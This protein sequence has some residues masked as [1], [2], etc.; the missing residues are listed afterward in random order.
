MQINMQTHGITQPTERDWTSESRP[1][2]ESI[3]IMSVR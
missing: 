1:A 3:P 2:E